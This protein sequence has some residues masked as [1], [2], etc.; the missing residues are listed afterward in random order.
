MVEAHNR[1]LLSPPD[2]F[3]YLPRFSGHPES[4]SN[5]YRSHDNYRCIH[6]MLRATSGSGRIN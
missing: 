3:A 1:L 5:R 4:P 2:T 6:R